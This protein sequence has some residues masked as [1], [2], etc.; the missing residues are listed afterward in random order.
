VFAN[1]LLFITIPSPR[2]IPGRIR[3]LVRRAG[4]IHVVTAVT[5]AKRRIPAMTTFTIDSQNNIT[6]CSSIKEANDN[7]QAERFSSPKELG[8]LAENWPG[9]R[10]VEIWNSLPGQKPVKKFTSRQAAVTR[11]W[12][13]IQSLAPHRAPQAPHVAPNNNKSG[14]RAHR[15]KRAT[16]RRGSKTAQ[17]VELLKRPHGVTLKDLM[18]ATQWQAHSVRGF[19]SGALRK[20]MGFTVEST[21]SADGERSYSIKA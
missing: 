11:I 2:I 10:L 16:A 1:I 18:A 5:T 17:V 21:K 8:R 4:V 14:R 13:T 19:I 7:P 12:K 3:L 6:A 9:S 20:K 15:A